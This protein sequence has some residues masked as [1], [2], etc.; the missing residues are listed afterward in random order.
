MIRNLRVLLP[1]T[2][3]AL[4]MTCIRK[5]LT[6]TRTG[7]LRCSEPQHCISSLTGFDLELGPKP[8]RAVLPG[9][10][11]LVST[12]SMLTLQT[13]SVPTATP[14][15]QS[16]SEG[17]GKEGSPEA[18]S[19]STLETAYEDTPLVL[20]SS[21]V[22]GRCSKDPGPRLALPVLEG[23]SWDG[24]ETNLALPRIRTRNLPHRRPAAH[25]LPAPVKVGIFV[26]IL[27]LGLDKSAVNPD[28]FCPRFLPALGVASGPPSSSTIPTCE[29]PGIEP[30]LPWWEAN[31][32]SNTT[33]GH[34]S[35]ELGP[36]ALNFAGLGRSQVNLIEVLL[37]KKSRA[38]RQGGI[39]LRLRANP[40]RLLGRK[41]MQ[42]NM[43]RGKEG[44]G[45][46]GLHFGAMTTSLSVLRASLNYEEQG[47]NFQERRKN[48]CDREHSG[49]SSWITNTTDTQ[50]GCRRRM[51]PIL[52]ATEGCPM[53]RNRAE[54]LSN[55]ELFIPDGH[56]GIDDVCLP[57]TIGDQLK[58]STILAASAAPA[59]AVGYQGVANERISCN[60]A[61]SLR[62]VHECRWEAEYDCHASLFMGSGTDECVAPSGQELQSE[63][64]AA[65]MVDILSW[66]PIVLG[67]HTSSISR[68]AAGMRSSEFERISDRFC[69]IGKSPP[70][71][72]NC[73][74][75]AN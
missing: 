53:R 63:E 58:M 1:A 5:E 44:F 14:R 60:T 45:S 40:L 56:L 19:S 57:R 21:L 20:R 11:T 28:Y 71:R 74:D 65:K 48:P 49:P 34:I 33:R 35:M 8:A 25:H 23:L 68:V 7:Q 15:S 3:V 39:L 72:A 2:L 55:S 32:L 64:P 46:H 36:S 41:I 66:S 37:S 17:M 13:T 22:D 12:A 43:H 75:Y 16:H 50:Y 24:L 61:A 4:S 30:G 38:R 62:S 51:S 29:N 47:K 70:Q 18:A 67:R 42:G 69:R 54:H 10:N 9:A 6:F 26:P 59:A 52:T 31:G 73:P 27:A